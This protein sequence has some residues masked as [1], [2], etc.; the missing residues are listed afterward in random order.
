MTRRPVASFAASAI[1]LVL[2]ALWLVWTVAVAAVWLLL[3]LAGRQR[4]ARRVAR[5]FLG[6]PRP[7]RIAARMPGRR[8]QA[9]AEAR[10]IRRMS[11]RRR[12]ELV[13]VLADRDGLSCQD[14]GCTLDPTAHHLAD[15]HPEVHHLVAW[16]KAK[17]LWWCDHPVNL[18]LL[19]GPCNRRIGDGTTRRLEAK[20][21][22][23]LAYYGYQEAA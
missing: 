20:R 18:V 23:L 17:G 8:R 9:P 7:A 3:A 16:C 15:E 10:S 6:F 13:A 21:H 14:C 22:E 2:A 5:G 12:G 11:S 4:D 19:C 1:W